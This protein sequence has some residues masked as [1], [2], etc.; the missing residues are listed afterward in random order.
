VELVG[1][2]GLEPPATSKVRLALR[3]PAR[4]CLIT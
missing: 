3:P 1:C 4:A 2:D